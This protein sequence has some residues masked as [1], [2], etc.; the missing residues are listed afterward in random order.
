[1]KFESSNEK[2]EK[3]KKWQELE[4]GLETTIDKLGKRIDPEIKFAI[5]AL[6]ANGFGTTGS[7]SGHVDRALPYPWV[8]VE[9]QL[10][11]QLLSDPRYIDLK[12]RARAARHEGGE[13]LTEIEQAEKKKLDQSQIEENEKAYQ[14][15]TSLLEEFYKINTSNNQVHLTIRKGG[16]N[17][18]RLQPEGV[19]TGKGWQE[20]VKA[21]SLEEKT[22]NLQIYRQEMD[23]FAT[24]LKQK[25]FET[26]A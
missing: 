5:V 26:N 1:M 19:P 2:T 17:Q 8:Q 15:L 23:R 12:T 10:A 11:E 25:F 14:R 3:E 6:K 24:F 22:N 21:M 4:N 7:C 18:S 9:S 16:W 13:E 20:L